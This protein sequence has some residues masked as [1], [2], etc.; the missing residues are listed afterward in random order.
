MAEEVIRIELGGSGGNAKSLQDL[1]KE[2]KELQNELSK[3]KEGSDSYINTLKKLGAVKDDIGDLRD[4]ISALNPE[5]KVAAFAKMGSTIASGFAAAQGAAA[6]FGA[7]SEELQKTMLKVQAAMALA[8][9]IKGIAGAAD[10]FRVLNAVMRANPAAALALAFA[11]LATAAVA[12]YKHFQDINSVSAKLEAQHEN[13]KESTASLTKSIDIQIQSL[14]GLKAN[15]D[16]ILELGEKKLKLNIELAKSNLQVALAKQFEAEQEFNYMEQSLRFAGKTEEA[17]KLRLI[18]T[19][20]QRDA[21]KQAVE[22]LKES[23]AGLQEFH[24]EAEQKKLDTTKALN[25]K[26]VADAER[27]AKEKLDIQKKYID[28]QLAYQKSAQDE[29]DRYIHETNVNARKR[30][31]EKREEEKAFDDEDLNQGFANIQAK[32]ERLAESEAKA[33]AEKQK[34]A[35]QNLAAT[36]QGL[37]A[38][39]ALTDLYFAHQL[40]QAKGNSEK[41]KEIRKKAFNVNKAFGVANA[42][43]DGVGA[44]QKAL[45]NPYPLNIVLAVLSGVLAAANIAKIASTKFDDG[46]SSSAASSDTGSLGSGAAPVVPQPTNTVTKIDDDGK[47]NKVGQ[48]TVKAVVVETDITDK[49]KRVNTIEESAKFG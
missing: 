18:R 8:D 26:A 16:K 5:G 7:E 15:E 21:T 22:G 4:T 41:E 14:K 42:V 48:P 11:S 1:K 29:I 49:Q 17:D 44:V 12:I 32:D 30:L 40:R 33:R 6:L 19:K 2:Y 43:I 9:G 27:A 28:E 31:E 23:I 36:K 37:Q 39:Q 13:L 10:A 47:V 25:D 46:G 24:N 38:A 3:T 34:T 45:N 20:E 35:D